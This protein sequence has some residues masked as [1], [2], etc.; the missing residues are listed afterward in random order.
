[1]PRLHTPT[2][3]TIAGARTH[4]PCLRAE[5]T[6]RP[7][8]NAF[9]CIATA[10]NVLLLTNRRS[11]CQQQRGL[12]RRSRAPTL[13]SRRAARTRAHRRARAGPCTRRDRPN[14]ARA[15]AVAKQPSG[16]RHTD[17]AMPTDHR[18]H[19]VAMRAADRRK[20][21]GRWGPALAPTAVHI[22]RAAPMPRPH[23]PTSRS[24]A[25]ARTHT[26]C[27]RAERTTRP[28]DMAFCCEP[29]ALHANEH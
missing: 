15:P 29:T 6:T 23:T 16:P 25:G 20:R 27:L 13:S 1:M 24:I 4:T 21:L 26:H 5:R 12:G 22:R 17:A 18:R 28:N 19:V 14:P 9:C 10:R 2:A 11:Q 3:R 8:E 7:N